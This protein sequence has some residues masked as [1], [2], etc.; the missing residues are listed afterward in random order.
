MHH[1][2][3]QVLARPDVPCA[4]GTACSVPRVTSDHCGQKQV[5]V[6]SFS[7][8]SS[9]FCIPRAASASES[10]VEWYQIPPIRTPGSVNT[11]QYSTNTHTLPCKLQ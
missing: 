1:L 10:R 4:A 3:R 2:H 8:T 11:V 5:H 6:I 7:T 9:N